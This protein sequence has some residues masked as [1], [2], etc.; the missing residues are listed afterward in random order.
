MFHLS[1]LFAI[2]SKKISRIGRVRV[3]AAA[4]TMIFGWLFTFAWVG[5]L[6]WLAWLLLRWLV[7]FDLR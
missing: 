7:S 1:E 6:A 4:A 5:L 3:R 2:S